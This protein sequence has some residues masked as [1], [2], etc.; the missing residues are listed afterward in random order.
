MGIRIGALAEFRR[1]ELALAQQV[2]QFEEMKADPELK[3]ELEFDSALTAFLDKHKVTRAQLLEYLEVEQAPEQK[4]KTRKAPH[5]KTRVYKNPETGEEITVRMNNNGKYK[6]WVSQYGAK[7]VE[8][9][10]AKIS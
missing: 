7:K 10:L 2:T 5:I 8:S 4:P 9:W 6:A 1:A 3:K